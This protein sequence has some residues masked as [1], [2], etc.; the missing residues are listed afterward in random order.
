[1]DLQ[2]VDHR[3]TTAF[4][5]TL[6]TFPKRAFREAD[7]KLTGARAAVYRTAKEAQTANQKERKKFD[8]DVQQW[9]DR[10]QKY[11]DQT[12]A[13]KTNEAYRALQH[14]IANAEAEITKAEDRELEIMMA[15]E[16]LE[17]ANKAVE[18]ILR[19]DE[20]LIASERKQIE[21]QEAEK[22]KE[23]AAALADRERVLALIPEEMRDLYTRVAKR[24]HGTAMAEIRDGQCRVLR[25]CASCLIYMKSC[26]AKKTKTSITAKLADAFFT[27]SIPSRLKPQRSRATPPHPLLHDSETAILAPRRGTFFRDRSGTEICV[28]C[29]SCQ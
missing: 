3:I 21:A 28:R 6:E 23:L 15:G 2:E 17:R 13:V 9:K 26:A 11:R 12:G 22:K 19:Q 14:E 1:M 29:L 16:E 25:A 27:C 8:L 24:H 7:L 4:R 5:T 18:N 20:Q 10:A